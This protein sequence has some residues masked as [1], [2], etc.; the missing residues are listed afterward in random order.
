MDPKALDDHLRRSLDDGSL[1]RAERSA[2]GAWFDAL[3]PEQVALARSRVFAIA[4]AALAER[5]AADVLSWCEAVASL[6]GARAL[7]RLQKERTVRQEAWFSPDDD[8]PARIRERIAAARQKL[9]VCVFTLTDDSIGQELIAAHHR[10][11]L[12]RVVTDDDKAHDLGSDI[13][14][15][16]QAGIAVRTDKSA[17]HMHHKFA[18]F[19]DALLLTGSYNWTRSAGRDNQENFIVSDDP[20]LVR[21][22]AAQFERLWRAFG[23]REG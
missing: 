6:L 21:R 15:L 12:V 19:D 7:D 14:M 23:G 10:G 20:V 13:A 1:S 4:K 3:M 2:L 16:R 18:V 17:P 5:S 9:D 11:V 22:F 8:C